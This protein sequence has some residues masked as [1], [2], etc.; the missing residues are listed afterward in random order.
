M[1]TPDGFG[2]SELAQVLFRIIG[3]PGQTAAGGTGPAA[4]GQA[5]RVV[6]PGKHSVA[7]TARNWATSTKLLSLCE[8][9]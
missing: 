8:D 6:P 9:S 7:A 1:H 3:T 5:S 4:G 2:P